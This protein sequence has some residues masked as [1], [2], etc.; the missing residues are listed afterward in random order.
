MCFTDP[1]RASQLNWETCRN[2]VQ[3]IARGL[4]YLHEE[5]G[6]W[7]VHRD[8]N[9]TN[10]LLDLDMKPKIAGFGLARLMRD[11]DNE[12]ESTVIAGTV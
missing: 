3:G 11:G 10:I 8:I 2:I 7:V 4:R 5:S 9:P 1:Q 12:V 6:L